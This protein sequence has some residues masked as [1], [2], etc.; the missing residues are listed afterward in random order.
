MDSGSGSESEFQLELGLASGLPGQSGTGTATGSGNSLALALA[1]LTGRL[2]R[3]YSGYYYSDNL[4]LPVQ[5]TQAITSSNSNVLLLTATGT[6]S[7]TGD[8]TSRCNVEVGAPNLN[9]KGAVACASGTRPLAVALVQ[10]WR[11]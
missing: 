11:I 4:K 5:V 8:T 10:R 1:I 2:D 3:L 9:W 7:G 6:G